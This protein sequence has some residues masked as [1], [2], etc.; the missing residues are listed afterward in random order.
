M[1]GVEQWKK[2][3]ADGKIN[4]ACDLIVK[5][6]DVPDKLLMKLVRTR[7][8]PVEYP[9]PDSRI[10]SAR[11]KDP[12][13]LSAIEVELLRLASFG[14]TT[15]HIASAVHLD[16]NTIAW[17]W[18]KIYRI[19]GIDKKVPVP[20]ALAVAEALRRSIIV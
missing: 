6:Q 15:A 11:R 2:I 17:H 5:T 16:D 8:V 1:A 7:L 10:Q 20:R 13:S 12:N 14:W 4:E 3:V 9:V 19:F 18:K